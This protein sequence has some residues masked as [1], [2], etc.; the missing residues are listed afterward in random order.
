MV[1]HGHAITDGIR[2]YA[3]MLTADPT[4]ARLDPFADRKPC[5]CPISNLPKSILSTV[6]VMDVHLEVE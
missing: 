1:F 3:V 2:A 6:E 4:R 5:V